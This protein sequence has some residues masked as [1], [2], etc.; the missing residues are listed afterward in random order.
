MCCSINANATRIPFHGQSQ[1]TSYVI[2]QFR[3]NPPATLATHTAP[4]VFVVAVLFFVQAGHLPRAVQVMVPTHVARSA[5]T[6]PLVAQALGTTKAALVEL[7][8]PTVA[9]VPTVT[10][11]VVVVSP[12][13]QPN[14]VYT[15][16][17]AIIKIMSTRSE[18]FDKMD[19]FS[20]VNLRIKDYRLVYINRLNASNSNHRQ[21]LI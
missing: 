13:H 8:C 10:F 5:V 19:E 9:K 3:S 14:S 17:N 18:Y 2:G 20:I 4:V 21:N 12:V 16:A 15:P 1:S 6:V 11:F 7:H